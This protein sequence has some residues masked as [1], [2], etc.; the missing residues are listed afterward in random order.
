MNDGGGRE[1]LVPLN[2][3]RYPPAPRLPRDYFSKKRRIMELGILYI[4]T[5]QGLQVDYSVESHAQDYENFVNVA[6]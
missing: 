1:Y 5:F 6:K 3:S 4:M 2:P